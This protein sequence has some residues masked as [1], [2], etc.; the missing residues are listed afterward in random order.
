MRVYVVNLIVSL[1]IFLVAIYS[2]V[3][4]GARA[5]FVIVVLF[6]LFT[7]FIIKENKIAIY[8]LMFFT[9]F[10]F[11]VS[12]YM[13]FREAALK[14]PIPQSQMEELREKRNKKI[15][16]NSEKELYLQSIGIKERPRKV[17]NYGMIG[18]ACLF[19]LV[20]YSKKMLE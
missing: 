2:Y 19:G 9:F 11:V 6:L 18:M 16:T 10:F 7:P 1:I 12:S 8:L 17:F 20:M 4:A 15:A 5:P 3:S 14:K 13:T